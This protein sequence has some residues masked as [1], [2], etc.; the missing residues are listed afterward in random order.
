[1]VNKTGCGRYQK[2][3][4]ENEDFCE[5]KNAKEGC[6]STT[7]RAL[8]NNNYKGEGRDLRLQKFKKTF[9][10]FLSKSRS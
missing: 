7:V 4:E 5:E 8:K 1:M 3:Q 10:Y 6:S 9:A 2:K